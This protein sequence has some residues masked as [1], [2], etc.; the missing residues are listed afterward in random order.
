M[1]IEAM[2][3]NFNKSKNNQLRMAFF[4]VIA[5]DLFNEKSEA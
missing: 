4:T 3:V 5:V 1:Q 2:T